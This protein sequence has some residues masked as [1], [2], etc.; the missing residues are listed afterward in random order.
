MAKPKHMMA[1][2]KAGESNDSPASLD[3]LHEARTK[4]KHA[5]TWLIMS[6]IVLIAGIVLISY[7]FVSSWLNQ[8][9]QNKVSATQES[10]VVAMTST[11]LSAEKERAI[12]F[13]KRLRDGV[14]R[15]ID[16]FDSNSSMPGVSEYREVLNIANDG[17]MGELI[18]PKIS[19][20]LPIYH[21]TTDDVLQ[22]GVG[23]VVNTSVPIGGESTHVVL[24]GHT[25]LPTAQIFDRLEEL[26]VGD[27]FIIRVLGEDCAYRVTSTEVV[28]P[29]QVNSLSI[30]PGKDQV[31]LVTCTPYGVNT[32][33]LLVHA[34]RTEVPSE[35][36]DQ[37]KLVNHSVDSPADL[38]KNP[39]LFALLGVV[40]AGI[41]AGIAVLI[42]KYTKV[43]SRK[44]K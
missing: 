35:W 30:E 28:L 5:R 9:A 25:G 44:K 29:N 17:V 37:N 1:V 24:A 11:D 26:Q 6:I 21:F 33:R 4:K 34:E 22:H 7:P 31:T 15:V 32:H 43:L 13:N 42:L 41:I 2:L 14:S 8:L 40:F 36:E 27:W 12:E 38:N 16:P 20:D 39:I 3:S 10:T 18:I 23:H 19:V